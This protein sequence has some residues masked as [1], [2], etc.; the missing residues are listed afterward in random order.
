MEDYLKF[1]YV[2]RV[3]SDFIASIFLSSSVLRIWFVAVD[4]IACLLIGIARDIYLSSARSFRLHVYC[5]LLVPLRC[6]FS[7]ICRP[8]AAIFFYLLQFLYGL[9]LVA[10]CFS[11]CWNVYCFCC[12]VKYYHCKRK[13][14]RCLYETTQIGE[15][16]LWILDFVEI[17]LRILSF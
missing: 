14:M 9:G 3:R 10:L 13:G 8:A 6:Q 11:V 7:G 17:L 16:S 12:I 15:F 1:F 4:E 2:W 5:I